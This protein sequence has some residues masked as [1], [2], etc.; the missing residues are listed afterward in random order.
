MGITHAPATAALAR[1]LRELRE[2][3]G[4]TLAALAAQSAVSRAT[5]SR[6]E[7]GETSP[8]AETLGRLATT[9]GLPISRLLSP[10]DDAF[11]PV[12]TRGQQTVW[13]DPVHQFTR[14]AVSP[15]NG[16]LSVELIECDLAPGQRIAYDAAAIPGQEHHLY[17]LSG[18]MEVTVEGC[19]HT[20]GAGDC[21]RYLLVGPTVFY[22]A[23]EPCRYLIALK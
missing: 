23:D 18:G 8:T 12:L 21:L 5:L 14:R 15:A 4:L 16:P 10:L 20:L 6:I 13:H 7:N 19:S 11:L 17:V 9:Y 3:R 1:H 22:T 2:A